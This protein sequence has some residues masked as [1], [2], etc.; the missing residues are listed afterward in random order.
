MSDLPKEPD[1]GNKLVVSRTGVSPVYRCLGKCRSLI[2][3][4]RQ[5]KGGT[6]KLV[7]WLTGILVNLATNLIA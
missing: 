7:D 5:H 1:G 3:Q 4:A 6:D 2:Y